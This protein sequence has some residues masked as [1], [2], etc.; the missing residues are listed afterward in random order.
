[1]NVLADCPIFSSFKIKINLKPEE[2]K[3]KIEDL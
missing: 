2:I 3:K 1:M